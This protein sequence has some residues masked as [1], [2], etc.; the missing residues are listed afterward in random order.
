LKARALNQAARELLLAQ[1]SDWPFIMTAGHMDSYARSRVEEH[2]V[3]FNRLH[4]QI[5]E[6]SIDEG[7]LPGWRKRT[8]FSPTWTT[9]SILPW[10]KRCRWK[11][12][13]TEYLSGKK[14]SGITEIAGRRKGLSTKL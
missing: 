7:W 3:R 9:G 6:D 5:S 10:R 11:N 8:T 4:R 13:P 2:M 14:Y 12:L 1:S